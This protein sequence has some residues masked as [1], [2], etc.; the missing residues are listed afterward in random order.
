MGVISTAKVVTASE[1]VLRPVTVQPGNREW[2]TAIECVNSS[3]W[4]LPPMIILK[5][6]T[7][8]S[9]W[10]TDLLT[11]YRRAGHLRSV[12]TVAQRIN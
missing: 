2:V 4:L 3:G 1:R 10:Y 9:T 7:H 8:I 12:K 11:P 6:K 5:G